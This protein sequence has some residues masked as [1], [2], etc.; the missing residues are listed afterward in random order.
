MY[1]VCSRINLKTLLPNI[2]MSLGKRI[3]FSVIPANGLLYFFESLSFI[4]PRKPFFT[5]LDSR[6]LLK[7]FTSVI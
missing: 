3:I 1:T 2:V 7:P 4:L 5:F 6:L